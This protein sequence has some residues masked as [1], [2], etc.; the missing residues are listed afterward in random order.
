[1]KQKVRIATFNLENLDDQADQSPTLQKRV[2]LVRPQLVRLDADILCLQEVNAQGAT[3]Q[4]RKLLAL[5]EL[6][7]DTSYAG[8][9]RESTKTN[10]GDYYKERNLIVLSR[11]EITEVKQYNNDLIDPPRYKK[12]TAV[13]PENE[14]EKVAWERPIL[15]VKIKLPNNKILNLLNLHLKSKIP[16]DVKGQRIDQYTWK[17]VPGWA[18]GYFISSMKRVGQSLEARVLIDRIFDNDPQAYIVVCGDFNSKIDNVPVMTIRG[19]VENTG[20]GELGGRVLIPCELTVP[21][22][23][24]YSLIH[25]GKGEMLDHLIVSRSLLSFYKMT[26]VHNEILHDESISFATDIKYPESDHAPVVA[27][28]N[29]E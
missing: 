1:M 27:E 28:F 5:E 24:R 25:Q 4:T 6:L 22:S 2:S 15:C 23:S 8:Y 16:A 13:P 12:V 11:Y 14:A 21:E 18:E 7:K 3:A 17:T 20:N 29:I 19:D 9:F 10:D 26:E